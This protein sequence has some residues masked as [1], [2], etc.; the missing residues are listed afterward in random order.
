MDYETTRKT[1]NIRY[2]SYR[3]GV[4][5]Q[6]SN[7]NS[8]GIAGRR[9]DSDKKMNSMNFGLKKTRPSQKTDGGSAQ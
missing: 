7:K 8:Q 4:P 1:L 5:A 3:R 2:K 6:R 9:F